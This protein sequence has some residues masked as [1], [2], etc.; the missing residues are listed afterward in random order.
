[1]DAV[2]SVAQS[3]RHPA[4]SVEPSNRT[5]SPEVGSALKKTES[6]TQSHDGIDRAEQTARQNDARQANK[7]PR[8]DIYV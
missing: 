2:N 4:N 8:V 1:M 5:Q 6:V 7:A 3:V